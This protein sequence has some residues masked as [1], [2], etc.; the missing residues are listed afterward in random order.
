MVNRRKFM[1]IGAA[2]VAATG[3]IPGCAQPDDGQDEYTLYR[4]GYPLTNYAAQLPTVPPAPL[5]PTS[6]DATT[7]YYNITMAPSTAQLLPTG[8]VTNL[9]TYNGTWPG[10][11][12]R[13]K[14]GRQAQVTYTN[15]L[16]QVT[17]IHNHGHMVP[18][19]SDGHPTDY[20]Y[21]G[22]SKTY[23]YPNNQLATTLWYHDHAMDVTGSQ[24]YKGLAGFYIIESQ[25]GDAD[26]TVQQQLPKGNYDYPL[27]FQDRK[28]DANNQLVY[29]P[30]ANSDIQNGWVGD[31]VFVNGQAVPTLKVEPRKYRFRLLNGSNARMYFLKLLDNATAVTVRQVASDGGLLPAPVARTMTYFASG[32]RLDVV[33]DFAAFA[34]KTLKF[35]N[36]TTEGGKTLDGTC[37]DIMAFEV[38]LPLNGTDTSSVPATLLPRVNYTLAQTTV[39]RTV[40]LDNWN[41]RTATW[42]LNGKAFDS[43]RIDFDNIKLGTYEVWTL[44]NN[45]SEVHPFH[46]HLIQFQVYDMNIKGNGVAPYPWWSGWKDTIF[47]P[48]WTKLRVI[49]KWEGYAGTYVCHCH[50]LEHE[51]HRMMMQ[52]RTVP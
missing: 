51:D 6:S 2:G 48:G 40:A 29:G 52:I 30:L 22:A 14:R 49:M 35:K 7:D 26:Y 37:P 32:E 13:V 41:S 21:P 20:I 43:A 4:S 33:I 45:T 46:I 19:T 3:L 28:F 27:V 42:T 39:A 34:G 44:D 9:W 17:S 36:Y 5:A 38:S 24:V 12:L 1:K 18:D 47:V 15:N 23:T 31:T 10:P 50:K 8:P 25:S 11:T 16:S